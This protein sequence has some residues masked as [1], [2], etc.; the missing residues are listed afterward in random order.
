[1]DDQNYSN[2]LLQM[3]ADR[4]GTVEYVSVFLSFVLTSLFL[5]YCNYR[6]THLNICI[7]INSFEE[8]AAMMSRKTQSAGG[9]NEDDELKTA[10]KLFDKV[11]RVKGPEPEIL[12]SHQYL[13]FRR[14]A[15]ISYLR[16]NCV[17]VSNPWAK[18]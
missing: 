2:T 11:F 3:D 6:N 12:L 5:D 9:D 16:V 1:M 4:T 8:F 15:T 13:L 14:M 7:N 17:K 10:F 18:T